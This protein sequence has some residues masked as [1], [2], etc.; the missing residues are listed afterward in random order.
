[1]RELSSE[2]LHEAFTLSTYLLRLSVAKEYVNRNDQIP[3][4]RATAETAGFYFRVIVRI[5][6]EL[7]LG[8][9]SAILRMG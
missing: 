8:G 2:S 9:G 5:G 7:R 3:I 4:T 1:M 6:L